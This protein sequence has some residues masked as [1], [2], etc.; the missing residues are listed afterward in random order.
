MWLGGSVTP[1]TG[2]DEAFSCH[3]DEMPMIW[4]LGG[5]AAAEL[6]IVHLLVSMWSGTAAWVVTVL[7]IAAVAQ[8]AWM[9]RAMINRP[10]LVSE[11]A[12][13]IR[14]RTRTPIVVPIDAI[15]RV[16][17]SALAPEPK[18]AGVFRGTLLAHPNITLR[19]ERPLSHA[20][21]RIEVIALRIDAPA[22]FR[23]AVEARRAQFQ[24]SGGEA[25]AG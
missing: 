5:L 15:A 21:R 9:V 17:D 23:A 2:N 11:R 19:L 20:A 18:G 7:T 13:T 10:V 22:A 12:V 1:G 6:M 4:M 8:A 16:E 24:G 25:P 3:R 14:F